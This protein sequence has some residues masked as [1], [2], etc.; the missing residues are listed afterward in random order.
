[1]A[2]NRF[3]IENAELLQAE[4]RESGFSSMTPG[5]RMALATFEAEGYVNGDGFASLF[6]YMSD[7]MLS[8]VIPGFRQFDGDGLAEL[9]E[10]AI[11]KFPKAPPL[12][13]QD[14]RAEILDQWSE[15][16]KNPF[17]K[18]EKKFMDIGHAQK[19]RLAFIAAHP[20]EFFQK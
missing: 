12:P 8:N 14:D 1:M 9:V 15:K 19:G 6:E 4:E 7:E 5:R 10:R 18:F 16:D 17:K 20:D 11:K 2:Q 13:P 3:D